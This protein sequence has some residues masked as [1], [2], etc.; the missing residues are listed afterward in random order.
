MPLML[1][2]NTTTLAASQYLSMADLAVKKSLS[3]LSSGKQIVSSSENAGGFAVSSKIKSSLQR[4]QRLRENLN[5]SISFLQVQ[6][7]ALTIA[8]KLLSRMS[9]L[10]TLSLDISKN[11]HDLENSNKEFLELQYELRTISKQKFNGISLFTNPQVHNHSL[12]SSTDGNGNVNMIVSLARNFITGEFVGASG[13]VLGGK[14]VNEFSS[15]TAP[16]EISTAAGAT[17]VD[18]NGQKIPLGSTDLNWSVTGKANSVVRVSKH[19]A[20]ADETP[21]AAWVGL[22]PGPAGDYFYS[23]SFDLGGYDL[24]NV[25]ISGQAAT[26]NAGRILVNGQ[27]MGINFPTNSYAN[28]QSFGLESSATG[29]LVDNVSTVPN[30]LIDG[31]NTLIVKVNNAGTNPGPTGL[32]F[33]QLNISAS[34]V[35]TSQVEDDSVQYSNLDQ[36]SMEDFAKF[37]QS[38]ST[39]L[40]QNGAEHSRIVHRLRDLESNNEH[41][42]LS[43]GRNMD[44]DY[45]KEMAELSKQK[46]LT[47]SSVQMM[48]SAVKLTEI[49]KQIM[50]I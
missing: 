23:M 5:N 17:G 40:A 49:A 6:G 26:D 25:K 1:N 44:L 12:Q 34:K 42:E 21:T 3:K 28:L 27:D 46:L 45:A 7:G 31:I 33:D 22:D 41:L 9:E 14:D 10:K 30:V 35:V 29:I 47:Q 32:L 13:K 38:L 16:I 20:W 36:F 2:S 50:G 24:S 18:N 48:G 8:G 43:Y 4:N 19:P 11:A 15:S 37:E 39:A